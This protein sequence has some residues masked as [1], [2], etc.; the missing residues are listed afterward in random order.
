MSDPLHEE[1]L[2]ALT[3]LF[4]LGLLGTALIWDDHGGDE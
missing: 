4:F 2:K 1:F 3:L